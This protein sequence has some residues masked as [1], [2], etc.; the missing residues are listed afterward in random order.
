MPA[1]RGGARL[2]HLGWRANGD[3]FD[4]ALAVNRLLA[5]GGRAWRLRAAAN[6]LDAGDYLIE[7][8]ES[9][10]AA[11]AGL[12]LKSALWEAALPNEAQA[13]NAAVPLLFAGTASRF[14][15]YAYYALCLLR[16]GVAYTPCDGATLS[17]GALDDANLLILPGGFSNWGIDN[18]E[19]VQGA[20]AR[21]RD[22]LARG[23]AAIGSC[24]GAYYLSM[25]RPGW[26]GTAQAKP[27][28]TH[29]YLQSGVGVVTLEMRKGPLALGCPPTMEV[30]YYHGPI[31]DLVG[32]DIDVA[33]TFRELALPGRL[34]I[35]NP[36]DR[37]TFERDMA[38]NAAILLATG[39]RGRAVLFSPHPE[40][41]DLI[42]KYIALDG[43]VRHYL[44]IRGLGT[45]R[46]TLRH[47]HICDSPSFRLVQNAID[48][49][50]TMAP[51]RPAATPSPVL[52]TSAR[53]GGSACDIIALLR[54]QVDA[55]PHFGAGDEGNLLRDIAARAAAH[56]DPVSERVAG[57]MK[58]FGELAAL[59]ASWNHMAATMEAHIDTVAERTVAQQLMELE[60]S[61]ALV[62]C[63][64]QVAELDLALAGRA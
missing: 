20:D 38:G 23:G 24:G 18:A 9:R 44:P 50:M 4:V 33:A 32:P 40:M 3:S 13:L 54:R 59:G 61:I 36:L 64:T 29:E 43:Y 63:W 8:T 11:I 34:A 60:L 47:Y 31:Y 35:D 56:I 62:E 25:G 6:Q 22:F 48:A 49:L 53:G 19:S 5:A 14:P 26:T 7:I 28:Y 42:R 16:L 46:D 37:D 41:G 27:L 15:Y 55:L 17:S 57:A 21:V 45:M 30:P 1:A 12:G 10:R 39:N 52:I 51:P 58:H 2:Y